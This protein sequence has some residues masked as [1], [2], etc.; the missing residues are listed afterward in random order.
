MSLGS[1][2]M[3]GHV[4]ALSLC[5]APLAVGAAETWQSALSRM[6]LGT[7]VTQL[8]RANCVGIMLRAFQSNTVVKA[9]VFMPGATD[10]FYFF[11]RAKAI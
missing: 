9:L 11:R 3:M 4:I 6:P 1:L 8:N 7:N 10:E 5:L 2:T